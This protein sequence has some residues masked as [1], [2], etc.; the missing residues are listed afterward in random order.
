MLDLPQLGMEPDA[1]F[2]PT[3]TALEVPNGLLAWGGD[4]DPKRLLAAYARGIFPWY[5]YGQPLLWWSPAPR[6]VIFPSDIHLSRRTRR[7]FN[8][9]RF[10]LTADTACRDVIEA[11]ALPRHGETGTWITNEMQR[12]FIELHKR[13][14]AHSVEVWQDDQLA[15]GIYGLAIGR[16]FF[17]ESMFSKRTDASKVALIALCQELVRRGYTLLD[18]Q[19]LNPHLVRMGAVEISRSEFESRLAH[20]VSVVR[21]PVSWTGNFNVSERW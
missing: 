12:A 10:K 1:P 19:I 7:R 5:T 16:I 2:P 6:C 17:G 11:C 4:L 9:G 8:T 20:G 15:G 13:G 3:D 18:C 14:H 21:D